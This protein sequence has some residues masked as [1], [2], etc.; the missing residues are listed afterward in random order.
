MNHPSDVVAL[1]PS[2]LRALARGC[3]VLSAAGLDVYLENDQWHWRWEL[4]HMCSARG[5]ATLED[6]FVDAL[7][8]WL[9]PDTLGRG[10]GRGMN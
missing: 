5:F 10:I 6:A 2:F 4:F 7:E 1:F 3:E 8:C 9:S